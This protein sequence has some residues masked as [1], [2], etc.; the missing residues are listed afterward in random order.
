M[1]VT[2]GIMDSVQFV[3]HEFKH[4]TPADLVEQFGGETV[5]M[6]FPRRVMIQ[7]QD[8]S[9]A[10]FDVG[11]HEVP[12]SLPP[13]VQQYLTDSGASVYH[14]P[15]PQVLRR[16]LMTEEHVRF[17]HDSGQELD[18]PGLQQLVDAMP[19]KMY[20]EFLEGFE[21]WKQHKVRIADG[22]QTAKDNNE[23][24]VPAGTSMPTVDPTQ[25]TAAN[26][27]LKS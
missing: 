21:G 9:K 6:K 20:D 13:H 11:V 14:A 15:Q 10:V 26:T 19:D 4:K 16:V 18:Q 25:D 12:A 27:E 24:P 7:L 5:T 22:E 2:G 1:T 3:N 17:A 8:S 23:P